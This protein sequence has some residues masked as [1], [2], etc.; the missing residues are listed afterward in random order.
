[1]ISGA[2]YGGM[3]LGLNGGM[4]TGTRAAKGAMD[5]IADIEDFELDE[6]MV[7]R[8]RDVVTAPARR[9]SGHAPA[10]LTQVLQHTFVP[11][12]ISI[13]KHEQR[14]TAALTLIQ[15][16]K[17]ELAPNLWAK[18]PHGWRMAHETKNMIE[19][20]ELGLKASLYRK[21]SRGSHFRED[22]PQRNDEEWLCWVLMKQV[23]GEDVYTKVPVP[24]EFRPDYTKPYDEIYPMTLPDVVKVSDK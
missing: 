17:T 13:Y 22:Y 19:N 21:E 10:W 6:E 5:Y 24:E 18:D 23:D 16:M 20:A 2:K 4:V 1:M 14:M 8:V 9:N 7:E 3:G 11:Y 12:Y 15:Y